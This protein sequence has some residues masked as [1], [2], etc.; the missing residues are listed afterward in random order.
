MIRHFLSKAILFLPA[1]RRM[2]GDRDKNKATRK[3]MQSPRPEHRIQLRTA[4]LT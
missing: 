3:T 4:L 2:T 1:G